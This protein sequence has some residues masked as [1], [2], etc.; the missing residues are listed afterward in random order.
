MG[1]PLPGLEK[2]CSILTTGQLMLNETTSEILNNSIIQQH[3]FSKS[4]KGLIRHRQEPITPIALEVMANFGY[5]RIKVGVTNL[6]RTVS[7]VS[8]DT[9]QNFSDLQKSGDSLAHMVLRL[10]VSRLRWGLCHH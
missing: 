6:T 7:Q 5:F 8:E 4:S 9:G 10:S 2:V 3:F 1:T